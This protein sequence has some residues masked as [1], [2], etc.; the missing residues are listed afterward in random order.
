MAV[1]RINWNTAARGKVVERALLIAGLPYLLVPDGVTVSSVSWTGDADPAWHATTTPDARGWLLVR[2]ELDPDVP[3]CAWEEN[4]SV[5][6]GTL[7]IG[8]LRFWLADPTEDVTAVT[9]AFASRDALPFTRLAAPVASGD[10][11]I[12]VESTAAFPSSGVV[13]L[14]RE[15]IEYASKTS[16][17]FAGCS[18]GTAG[19]K[20]RAYQADGQIHRV[21]GQPSGAAVESI[22]GLIGRRVTLW[23]LQVEGGVATN[24]TLLYDGRIAAGVGMLPNGAFE[25][26]VEH[27]LK[28]LQ[29]E[30]QPPTLS[31]YGYAHGSNP[32]RQGATL[33]GAFYGSPVWAQWTDRA[34]HDEYITLS[35]DSGDPDFGGWSPS[36]AL[37]LERWNRAA[38]VGGYA[39]RATLLASGTLSVTA[40][41]AVNDRRLT[42]WFSWAEQDRSDPSDSDATRDNATVYSVGSMPEH[43]Y[44]LAGALHLDDGALAQIPAVPSNPVHNVTLA[45]G[46][47]DAVL[48]YWTLSAERDNGALEKATVVSRV[49]TVEATGVT[50]AAIEAPGQELHLAPSQLPWLFTRAAVASV[51]LYARGTFWWST[52]RYGVLAQIDALRGF[53]QIADSIDWAQLQRVGERSSVHGTRREYVV[54]LSKPVAE[55]LRNE[56]ALAGA[57]ISLWHGRLALAQ[58]RDVAQTE[59]FDGTLTSEHLRWETS[60]EAREVTDGLAT[61]YKVTLETG[62]T[63]TV[64]DAGAVAESGAGA[65]IEATMPRG[66]LPADA[67]SD[68]AVHARIVEIGQAL[69]APWVRSYEVV[70]WPGDMRL[71]GYQIGHVLTLSDWLIPDQLGGR[72]LDAVAATVLGRR[73]DLDAGTVDLKLRVSPTAVSGYAPE[74][75]V[76]SISGA[77]LTLDTVT[78]DA[79]GFADDLNPDGSPRTDGGA[80]TFSVGH[81][82][83]L[84]ELDTNSPTTPFEAEVLSI[85]GDTITLDAAPGATWEGLATSGM[86][87]LSFDDYSTSISDQHRWCYIA[88]RTTLQHADGKQ[89]RRW[90]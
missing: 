46:I 52:L 59:A 5:V 58:I 30:S 3:A 81:K 22:P 14:G 24:P 87:L 4:A 44:W 69:L 73:P 15:R 70:S 85:S 18:R 74:A 9:T 68:S 40:S 54:D 29:Q 48:A 79:A 67:I 84:L 38:R 28:A 7:D 72:G 31:L 56:A 10:G 71:A 36:R 45:G 55:L 26:P 21:Y 20:A 89:G 57:S 37:Y 13:H 76:A 8:S 23:A 16:T 90:A 65:T 50:C 32:R 43:C 51:G 63:I 75:L 60:A 2:S 35:S 64:T 61:S 80:G 11:T 53:D 86:V 42:V 34:G 66:L 6:Q 78:I 19:T 25:L 33:T 39:E 49:V 12:T 17:T 27:A 62:D 88:S 41:D 83:T 82:V 47:V 77:V 1:E